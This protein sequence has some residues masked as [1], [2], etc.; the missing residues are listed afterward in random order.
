MAIGTDKQHA[1][2]TSSSATGT[3]GSSGD[4]SSAH[5]LHEHDAR[6]PDNVHLLI[7]GQSHHEDQ[8]HHGKET[9]LQS[10]M[11][12]HLHELLDAATGSSSLSSAAAGQGGRKA[13]LQRKQAVAGGKG[14]GAC[15][16]RVRVPLFC[17]WRD[18]GVNQCVRLRVCA[19]AG[20]AG[21]QK[22]A[23]A[24][25]GSQRKAGKAAAGKGKQA[26]KQAAGG[27][28]AKGAAAAVGDG[29]AAAVSDDTKGASAEVRFL[30]QGR[31]FGKSGESKV[32]AA[33]ACQR[34]RLGVCLVRRAPSTQQVAYGRT[35][36]GPGCKG[37]G[38]AC[39]L[40]GGTIHTLFTSN[41]SPVSPSAASLDRSPRWAWRSSGRA[42]LTL[43]VRACVPGSSNLALSST[44]VPELPGQDHVSVGGG[45]GARAG[46]T[47][48]GEGR[49]DE[50]PLEE[51]A[52]PHSCSGA[53]A[54]A[55]CA[56]LGSRV[57]TWHLV[58]KAPGG[59]H[60]VAMTRI[61][62]RTT[63]DELMDEVRAGAHVFRAFVTA[64]G[65]A[66]CTCPLPPAL[67]LS[68]VAST[69]PYVCAA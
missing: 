44:A 3:T 64:G 14:A 57:A 56:H 9:M 16:A 21:D 27:G 23:A 39:G 68:P 42:G 38:K 2:T 31:L 12:G 51:K 13:G 45:W 18:A 58:R 26:A 36:P 65:G 59:S 22:L 54:H 53:C 20:G 47:A 19:G 25:E 33:A 52:S 17:T 46:G 41:G 32:K 6:H 63:P 30:F 40:P 10:L 49:A 48:W 37:A 43:A 15:S 1:I 34:A 8:P 66:A 11:H 4:G 62:H 28:G 24:A 61:L 69:V 35:A 50:A 7:K 5:Q 29:K 55:C 60:L 67:C